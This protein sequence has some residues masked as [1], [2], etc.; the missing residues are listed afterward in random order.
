MNQQEYVDYFEELARQHAV[1]RHTDEQKRFYVV[2]DNE[3]S[4]VTRNIRNLRLPCVL[5]DQYYDTPS[6][7]NDNFKTTVTG[8]ITVLIATRKGDENDER[9]AQQEAARIAQSFLNRMFFDCTAMKGKL[10]N[11]RIKPSTEFEGEPFPTI[12]DVAAG[13]GYPF[14][15]ELPHSFAID[16]NDWLDMG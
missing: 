9:R 16:K 10:F 2:K 11:R 5:L 15:W 8:G 14:E 7:T 4:V 13:W 12:A 3:Y 6:R 1:I